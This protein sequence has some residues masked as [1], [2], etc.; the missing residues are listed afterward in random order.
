MNHNKMKKIEF[1]TLE[2]YERYAFLVLWWMLIRYLPPKLSFIYWLILRVFGAKIS[3]SSKIYCSAKV[4][5]PRK[6]TL[7]DNSCIGPRCNIYNVADVYIG[8]DV[9]I[10]QDTTLCTASHNYRSAKF[11]LIGAEICIENT[12]WIASECFVGPGI[13]I[14]N[15]VVVCAR[16]AVFNSIP[17]NCKVIGNPA[18]IK[19]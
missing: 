13:H 18:R 8:S 16:S 12:V 9:I 4:W 6:L 14:S 15:G 5:W 2:K 7:G 19:D 3:I 17:S 1:T 11:E 10:S